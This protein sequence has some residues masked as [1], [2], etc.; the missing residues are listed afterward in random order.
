MKK[1]FKSYLIFIFIIGIFSL[2]F[3]V[4]PN[5]NNQIYAESDAVFGSYTQLVRSYQDYSYDYNNEELPDS[6]SMRDTYML[7]AKQQ[8]SLG[9]CWCFASQ[10]TLETTVMKATGEYLDL[11]EAWIST[12]LTYGD[13]YSYL[14]NYNLI[15]NEQYLN[16]NGGWFLGYDI[17]AKEYGLVLEQDFEYEDAYEVTNKNVDDYF[18]LYSQYANHDLYDNLEAGRFLNYTNQTNRELIMNSIKNHILKNGAVTASLRFTELASTSSSIVYKVPS[19]NVDE[20]HAMTLIGWDDSISITTGGT[21]YTGAWIA[22]N[23]YG[24]ENHVS[25]GT[26]GIVYILYDDQDYD[27]YFWGYKYNEE[28]NSSLD[29]DD[30]ITASTSQN[31]NI[32]YQ[33]SNVDITYGYEITDGASINSIKIYKNQ[34]DVTKDFNIDP[35]TNQQKINIQKNSALNGTYKVVIEYSLDNQTSYHINEFF[36]CDGTE[37]NYVYY[38]TNTDGYS[39]V[40]N[41]GRYQLYNSFDIES[42]TLVYATSTTTDSIHIKFVFATY[43]DIKQID[44]NGRYWYTNTSSMLRKNYLYI[45]FEFDTSVKTEYEFKFTTNQGTQKILKLKILTL[46]SSNASNNALTKVN[47]FVDGGDNSCNDKKVIVNKTNNAVLNNPTKENYIFDGWYYSKNFEES[48]KLKTNDSNQYILE[49]SKLTIETPTV[50]YTTGFNSYWKQISVAFVY[51]KWIK[52]TCIVN[53]NTN[54]GSLVDTVTVDYGKT[55]SSVNSTKLGFTFEGWYTDAKFNEKWDFNSAVTSDMTLYAKFNLNPVTNLNIS[56]NSLNQIVGEEFNISVS[57]EHEIKDLL[58][59]SYV[60]YKDNEILLDK[61]TATISDTINKYCTTSYKVNVFIEYDLQVLESYSTIQ[62]SASYDLKEIGITYNKN[63][64]FEITDEDSY[65]SSYL[66]TV[67]KSSNSIKSFTTTNKTINIENYI[68]SSGIYQIGVIKTYDG[69]SLTEVIS[70]NVEFVQISYENVETQSVIV[71]KGFKIT[72]ITSPVKKGYTFENWKVNNVQIEFPFTVEEDTIIV[73]NWNIKPI[74][75]VQIFGDSKQY[76]NYSFDITLDFEHEL[77]DNVSISVEWYKDDALL[78]TSNNLLLTQSLHLVG[79][80]EYYAILTITHGDQ[81]ATL[82]SNKISIKTS[83]LL[84]EIAVNYANNLVFEIV[85]ND[86]YNCTYE[87]LVYFDNNL[88]DTFETQNKQININQYIT[89]KGVY[90]IGVKKKIGE[91]IKEEVSSEVIQIFEITLINNKAMQT[92]HSTI[93]KEFNT[94]LSQPDSIVE[95]GY[96][97]FGWFL[98]HLNSQPCNFPITVTNDLTIYGKMSLCSLNINGIDDITFTY[99]QNIHSISPTV[100]HILQGGNYLY[101]WEKT[102]NDNFDNNNSILQVQFV[103]DSGEYTFT[104]SYTLNG[105]IVT[106]QKTISVNIL[107]AQTVIDTSG[108]QKEFT[109][110]GNTHTINS[111]ASLS[112]NEEFADITYSN[113]TFLNVPTNQKLN[114]TVKVNETENYLAGQTTVEININKA[115]SSI[116]LDKYQTYTYSKTEIVPEYSLN[117]T[118]QN[119][120]LSDTPIDIGE[121]ENIIIRALES[122]NYNSTEETFTIKIN[123]KNIKVKVNDY[124]DYWLFEKQEFSYTVL[125]GEIFSGDELYETFTF[126]NNVKFGKNILTMI[127][128][129]VNYNVEILNGIYTLSILP[130]SIIAVI[131]FAIIV[132]LIVLKIRTKINIKK[133]TISSISMSNY[134]QQKNLKNTNKVLEEDDDIIKHININ[135]NDTVVQKTTIP[136]RPAPP[137]RP[138]LP[139]KPKNKPSLPPRPPKQSK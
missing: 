51:A 68:Q 39:I 117:N 79:D 82:P 30:K 126:E 76:I 40:K 131:I 8:S 104:A 109:Y 37:I 110:D 90:S 125:S 15:T 132:L 85:D 21:T 72:N 91:Q 133:A 115:N 23:S 105:D 103:K 29:Y 138:P 122:T 106:N 81:S 113:N 66:V 56:I 87:T 100:T 54:G 28:L 1:K 46:L 12:A 121:Y 55:L 13:K 78:T 107:K 97:F 41:N 26:Q 38:G 59:I 134:V 36:V 25:T 32:F 18:D 27:L 101:S 50:V 70:N 74:T 53:F 98:D 6:Y 52:S 116:T 69:Q 14:P 47:Y 9:L 44:F 43:H 11:S 75:S 137:T 124:K 80:F 24:N 89:Q 108:I 58:T 94:E 111:G 10:T 31:Q 114:V 123:P 136:K 3:F 86:P 65:E 119:I 20:G 64:T 93:L 5:K 35:D 49:Y 67:Y 60:W 57:F 84:T 127:V 102:N 120:Y 92:Q 48:S 99:D 112:R 135:K 128:E 63:F 118:E 62:V 61:N 17:V 7:Y 45:E 88:L 96:N 139:P 2:S 22:L 95:N 71:D 83:Y 16:G 42:E 129:N 19:T 77:K 33:Q 130:H 73:A 4:L 34:L